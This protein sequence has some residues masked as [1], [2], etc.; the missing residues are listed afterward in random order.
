MSNKAYEMKK[1]QRLDRPGLKFSRESRKGLLAEESG[2]KIRNR[3]G[4]RIKSLEQFKLRFNAV[5]ILTTALE[6]L[7]IIHP[8]QT[9]T[10]TTALQPIAAILHMDIGTA[11]TITTRTTIT[12]ASTG[13]TITT[14]LMAA[15]LMDLMTI[16]T[17]TTMVEGL[18]D[19]SLKINNKLKRDLR[20]RE[21]FRAERRLNAAQV[22]AVTLSMEPLHVCR[23][24][25][26]QLSSNLVKSLQSNVLAPPSH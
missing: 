25:T 26:R 8:V 1:L 13:I 14:M 17:T 11:M 24:V 15:T 16:T 6:V 12:L 22:A 4:Q 7:P 2:L 20:S 5:T 21:F 3:L 23:L 19:Y 9:M 18:E 10:L